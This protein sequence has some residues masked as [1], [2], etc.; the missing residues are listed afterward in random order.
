MCRVGVGQ[1]AQAELL[2]LAQSLHVTCVD[3]FRCEGP[4][5]R[6]CLVSFSGGNAIFNAWSII[7]AFTIKKAPPNIARPTKRRVPL[8][9]ALNSAL[10]WYVGAMSGA[11]FFRY[12][13]LS[14]DVPF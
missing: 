3:K 6:E 7:F 14:H 12:D 13:A 10:D 5:I 1:V 11:W 8:D 4:S 2:K 9:S